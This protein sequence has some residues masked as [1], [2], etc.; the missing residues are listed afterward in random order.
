MREADAAVRRELAM[1]DLDDTTLAVR[2]L[3]SA[4]HDLTI[5]TAHRTGMNVS[6]MTAV[7]QLSEHGPMGVAE[8]ARRLGV[9]SP[10]VS[11]LVDRLERAGHVQ[12]VRDTVD[13]RRVRITD[14]PLGRA[15]TT[16][17]WLPAIREINQVGRSLSDAE[18]V[19]ARELLDRLTAAMLREDHAPG[20]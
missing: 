20:A 6:D 18:H 5:R 1:S 13:R 17:A 8:L 10:A 7:M 9:S 19:A 3:I 12:R 2:R 15:A 4:A 16:D 14:T 11:V